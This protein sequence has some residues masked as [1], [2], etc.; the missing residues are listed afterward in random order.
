MNNCIGINKDFKKCIKTVLF[1]VTL[2]NTFTNVN[3]QKLY[4]KV[5]PIFVVA[6]SYIIIFS[7][8]M[9][10]NNLGFFLNFLFVLGI[11]YRSIS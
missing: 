2:T 5:F 4:C 10:V 9:P 11:T 1:V 8:F 6:F 3:T 7:H